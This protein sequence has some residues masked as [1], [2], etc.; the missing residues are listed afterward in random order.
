[1]R[2]KRIYDPKRFEMRDGLKALM[3]SKRDDW[4]TPQALFDKLHEQ[5]K[6]DADVDFSDPLIPGWKPGR[7]ALQKTWPRASAYYC[8]PP[9][10]RDIG[11]WL[12]RGLEASKKGAVVVFLLPARTD[13]Q[14]FHEYAPKG[15]VWFFR[16]RLKFAFPGGETEAGAPFPSMLLIF[17]KRKRCVRYVDWREFTKG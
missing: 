6:F 10:G 15:E 17:G 1:M 12:H 3:S 2:I 5:F 11:L 9:Y 7:C 8:N 13:T 16:G 14:W 4:R